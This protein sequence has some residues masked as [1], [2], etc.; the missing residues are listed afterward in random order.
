MDVLNNVFG[1]I[2]LLVAGVN[3]LIGGA[4]VMG[5]VPSIASIS[6]NYF[7]IGALFISEGFE[8]FGENR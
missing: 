6:L 4:V 3:I 7:L 5:Y 1:V 2:I 8:W